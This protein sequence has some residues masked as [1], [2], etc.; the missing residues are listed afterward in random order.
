MEGLSVKALEKLCETII[1]SKTENDEH[2]AKLSKKQFISPTVTENLDV[3]HTIVSI[4][5]VFIKFLKL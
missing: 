3:N 4:V 1:N 2:V 5:S